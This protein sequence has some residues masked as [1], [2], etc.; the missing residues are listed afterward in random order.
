MFG[1]EAALEGRLGRDPE[2]KMVKGGALALVTLAIAVDDTSPKEG[3]SR[4]VTWVNVKLFGDRAQYLHETVK[5]GGRVYCEGK[6]SLDTWTG[7]DGAERHGLS[8][9][10]HRVEV[11]GQIG[12]QRP[13]KTDRRQQASGALLAAGTRAQAP[14]EPPHHEQDDMNQPL[15]F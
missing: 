9:M 3:E 5:K 12:R 8:L 14:L 13:R 6:L 1:I 4:P 7:R 11:L 15:P 10:A 2:L